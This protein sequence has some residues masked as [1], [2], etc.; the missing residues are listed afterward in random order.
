MLEQ[1]GALKIPEE[2]KAEL[3]ARIG[4]RVQRIYPA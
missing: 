4:R 2:V 1:A 3:A